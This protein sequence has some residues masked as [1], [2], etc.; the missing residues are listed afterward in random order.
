V[1]ATPEFLG[2]DVFNFVNKYPVPKR[3]G[4]STTTFTKDAEKYDTKCQS[5][6]KLDD[7]L[8]TLHKGVTFT[9]IN[10]QFQSS[11]SN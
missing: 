6:P 4:S 10:S 3:D 8:F 9:D 1:A 7:S 5:L 11:S 2:G